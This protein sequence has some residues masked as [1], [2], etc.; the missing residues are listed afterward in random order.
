MPSAPLF[1]ARFERPKPTG[2]QFLLLTGSSILPVRIPV[3]P[4]VPDAILN[5]A[6]WGREHMKLRYKVLT[7]SAALGFA[8]IPAGATEVSSAAASTPT[9]CASDTSNCLNDWYNG[10]TQI[11]IF[12]PGN[13]N[14]AFY[15]QPLNR[16]GNNDIVAHN[17]GN[18]AND[19]PFA[20]HR[21]GENHLGQEI[22]QLVYVGTGNNI[23]CVGVNPNSDPPAVLTQS[24]QVRPQPG[25]LTQ[26]CG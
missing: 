15:P 26:P 3:S 5:A 16:C 11:H 19:C 13:T 4:L 6:V 10:I 17:P 25:H 7:A 9:I 20:I 14:E 21:G 24:Q 1:T 23:D 18:P 22:V 2:L 12:V 8:A